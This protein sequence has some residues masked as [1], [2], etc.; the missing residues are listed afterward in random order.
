MM[1]IMSLIK[2]KF[3]QTANAMRYMSRVN[4][5][6]NTFSL[7]LKVRVENKYQLQ[8]RSVMNIVR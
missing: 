1:I 3:A 8:K 2:P 4:V 6:Q 5:K 7:F